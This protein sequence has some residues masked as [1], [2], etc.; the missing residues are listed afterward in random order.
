MLVVVLVVF[1][2]PTLGATL[3]LFR[4][5]LSVCLSK[6]VTPSV[7]QYCMQDL[8]ICTKFGR[9]ANLVNFLQYKVHFTRVV[10]CFPFTVLLHGLE[11]HVN[12]LYFYVVAFSAAWL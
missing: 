3:L 2:H 5:R 9:R 11:T 1:T 10:L 8:E 7:W 4:L 6:I 12:D